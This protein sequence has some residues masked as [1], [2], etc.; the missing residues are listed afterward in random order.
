MNRRKFLK[1][2]AGIFIPSIC[3]G[4]FTYTD[5]PFL[6]GKPDANA[7]LLTGLQLAWGPG[8]SGSCGNSGPPGIA[9]LGQ[10]YGPNGFTPSCCETTPNVAG[11][12]N[13]VSA[14]D[15]H[16]NWVTRKD[17]RVY[18]ASNSKIAFGAGVQG[19][20]ICWSN[21][22]SITNSVNAPV[23][24]K[25]GSTNEFY[26]GVSGTSHWIWLIHDLSNAGQTID[27][28]LITASTWYMLAAGYDGTNQWFQTG[29]GSS[30]GSRTTNAISGIR[31]DTNPFTAGGYSDATL[32]A[33]ANTLPID[34]YAATVLFW[35][36]SLSTTEVAQVF[37]GGNGLALP[38]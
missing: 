36:R 37:N 26:L 7:N 3:L 11:P 8:S 25:W 12:G 19:T 31:S 20:V 27:A 22:N 28:G 29:S 24:C 16:S 34:G 5:I 21:I 6:A 9:G 2:A 10:D 35:N 32:G 13:I 15:F 23:V 17:E 1:T 18:C 4:Q 33:C 30:L 38:F 14:T